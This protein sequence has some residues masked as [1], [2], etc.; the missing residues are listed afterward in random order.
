M[1]NKAFSLLFVLMTLSSLAAVHFILNERVID[2]N[3]V[4]KFSTR[5]TDGTFTGLKGQVTF[6]P[7]QLESAFIDISIDAKTI[8]TDNKKKNEHANSPDWLDTEKYPEILFT[9]KSFKKENDQIVVTGE[10]T[11]H[12]VTKTVSIPFNYADEDGRFN[13]SFVIDRNDYG[14][15]GVG[16]KANFVG[17]DI[18]INFN[19]PTSLKE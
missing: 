7:D 14:V 6:S 4:L 5:S 11:L 1:K 15:T 10:L 16:L 13:G 19:I 17:D 2:E 9:S 8:D 12:G 3:Y 18:E